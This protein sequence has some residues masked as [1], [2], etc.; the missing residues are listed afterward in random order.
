[1][2]DAESLAL[3]HT[4]MVDVSGNLFDGHDE[5]VHLEP[6]HVL[7]LAHPMEMTSRELGA[8]REHK[9][10]EGLHHYIEQFDRRGVSP[11]EFEQTW[12]RLE[13]VRTPRKLIT[14]MRR[15]RQWW[16][17]DRAATRRLA[18]LNAELCLSMKPHGKR[19]TLPLLRTPA[20]ERIDPGELPPRV[21]SELL[22][23]L[24]V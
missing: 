17:S 11:G 4:V 6:H 22:C 8:W 16:R 18:H 19:L 13:H 12:R 9:V 21:L 1:M 7:A 20:G 15:V 23:E 24:G 5:R 3:E 14:R 2:Y 10:N